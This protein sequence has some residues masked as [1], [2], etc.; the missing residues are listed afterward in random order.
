MTI[1]KASAASSKKSPARAY[2]DFFRRFVAGTDEIP[3]DDFLRCAG[4]ELKVES[5][6]TTDL[7]FWPGAQSGKGRDGQRS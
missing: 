5:H 1:A 6:K 2:K 7:G 3:Y 4:L